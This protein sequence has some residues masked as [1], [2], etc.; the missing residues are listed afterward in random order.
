M[1][2]LIMGRYWSKTLL[3]ET[4]NGRRRTMESH[5]HKLLLTDDL[6][7]KD[8]DNEYRDIIKASGGNGYAA[9]HNIIRLHL[10]QLTEKKV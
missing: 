5:I 3:G 9:L 4:I 1:I 10:P 6:F 7:S 8:C 2:D